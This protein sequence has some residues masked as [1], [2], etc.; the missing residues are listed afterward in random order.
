MAKIYFNL[1]IHGR[2]TIDDVP[3]ML[4]EQ[5]QEYKTGQQPEKAYSQKVELF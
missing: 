3:A 2:K 5:V 1:I 4:R